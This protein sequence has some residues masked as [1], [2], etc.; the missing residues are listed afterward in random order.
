MSAR[1][2][3][4]WFKLDNA[5]KLYPAIATSRW[6]S[7]FRVSAVLKEP[8]APDALQSALD[9]VLPRFPSMAVC[10]RRG[11]FWY[12]LEANDRPLR[13]APDTGHPCLR[14]RWKEN[15]GYLLRVLYYQRRISVEFFHSLTDGSGGF[16]FLKTLTA[17]YLRLKG[18]RILPGEGVL[19]VKRKPSPGEIEDAFQRVPL[20]KV[21]LS[22]RDS[23]AY[24]LPG[25]LEPPH[26]LHVI[27]ALMP[28]DKVNEQCKRL[29]ATVTEYLAAAILFSAYQIQRREGK[30]KI[31]P[32]RVSVPINLRNLFQTETLRNFSSFVNVEIDPRLGG[33]YLRGGRARH[34]QLHALC[35][36][37]KALVRGCGH[38]CGERKE[39][40]FAPV[41]AAVEEPGH[42]H[43]V[44]PCGRKNDDRDADQHRPHER[45]QGHASAHRPV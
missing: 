28:F 9:R 39:P 24:R 14:F 44:S 33:L 1:R 11:I 34:A 18:A 21:K 30:R 16:V 36:E 41:P 37:P 38:Q 13:V 10:M 23:P 8:V 22:R 4:Q 35:P 19:D 25:E 20:P 29:G 7:I 5:G 31:R 43:G 32:I 2:K 40:F 45:A 3:Q 12:Y 15:N 6:S 26:T 42:Q 27:A 17:E